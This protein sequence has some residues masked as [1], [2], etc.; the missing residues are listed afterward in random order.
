MF[1]SAGRVFQFANGRRVV[2]LLQKDRICNYINW[3]GVA[4]TAHSMLWA[5]SFGLFMYVTVFVLG[6]ENKDISGGRK[7]AVPVGKLQIFLTECR[8]GSDRKCTSVP[9]ELTRTV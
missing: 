8:L 1:L 3:N 4:L 2:L 7:R 5:C 9:C 6:I